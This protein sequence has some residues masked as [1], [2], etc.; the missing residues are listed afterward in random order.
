MMTV[1]IPL[2]QLIRALIPTLFIPWL[3]ACGLLPLATHAN[4]PAQARGIADPTTIT[5]R[6]R[7]IDLRCATVQHNVR[8]FSPSRDLASK[9]DDNAQIRARHLRPSDLRNGVFVGIA[10]SG[11]GMRAANFA[12][13]ILYELEA[14]GVLPNHV[15]VISS[16]S[17]GS[18][19]AAYYGLYAGQDQWTNREQFKERLRTNLEAIWLRRLLLPHNILRVVGTKFNR[20]DVMAGVFD[21][22]FFGG[23]WQG[24]QAM[25]TRQPQIL[26][27]ASVRASGCYAF[28]FS[29]EVLSAMGSRLDTYPIAYA[30]MASGAFPAV[31]HDVTLR[32]F[33]LPDNVRSQ[34][35]HFYYHLNDGGPADNL[36]VYTLF[37]EGERLVSDLRTDVRDCFLF[38]V[39]AHAQP[40]SGPY[41][42]YRW[43]QSSSRSL[44]DTILD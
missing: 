28:V 25:P 29:D 15:S 19:P 42:L 22:V 4:G 33:A 12:A 2:R 43:D 7:A 13:A 3:S 24:F 21:D 44:T 41:Q 26:I 23:A 31:F 8:R 9:W 36:G 40:E 32:A 10:L 39:D 1:A 18:I 5:F 6:Q 34:G 11:G 27:N 16:V 35:K 38:V 14:L 17:G 37:D 30:V 20:T